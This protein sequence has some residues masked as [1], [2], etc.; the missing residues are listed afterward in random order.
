MA[1]GTLRA[2]FGVEG[3]ELLLHIFGGGSNCSNNLMSRFAVRQ[4]SSFS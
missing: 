1:S 3:N 2:D 4:H